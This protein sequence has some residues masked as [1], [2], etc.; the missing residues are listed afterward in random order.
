MAIKP[1]SGQCNRSP[2]N[3]FSGHILAGLCAASLL[4]A[5]PALAPRLRWPKAAA[6]GRPALAAGERQAA[7]RQAA[8]PQVDW[9]DHLEARSPV[10]P[11]WAAPASHRA[12]PR[13]RAPSCRRPAPARRGWRPHV[14]RRIEQRHHLAQYARRR[15]QHQ[16]LDRAGR[17]RPAAVGQRHPRSWRGIRG[18]RRHDRNQCERS[19]PGAARGARRDDRLRLGPGPDHDRPR[20]RGCRHRRLARNGLGARRQCLCRRAGEAGQLHPAGDR[21]VPQANRPRTGAPNSRPGHGGQPCRCAV[22][23]RRRASRRTRAR[24]AASAPIAS[25]ARRQPSRPGRSAARAADA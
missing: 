2:S 6:A 3:S 16:H 8:A 15:R 5:S 9:G 25:Q 4:A 7:A 24:C 23:S 19:S 12:R 22:R 10:L 1:R 21:A 17:R 20:G 18:D 13:L 11:R 14:R